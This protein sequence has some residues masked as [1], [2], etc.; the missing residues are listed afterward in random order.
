ML[1][2][3]RLTLLKLALIHVEYEI[4]HIQATRALDHLARRIAYR[5]QTILAS[6]IRQLEAR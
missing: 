1:N 5:R 2:I 3:V 4:K 6:K